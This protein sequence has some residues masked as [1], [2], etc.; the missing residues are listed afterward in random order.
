M[1]EGL[2]FHPLADIFPLMEGAELDALVADIK[3]NG[4]RE[5]IECYEGQVIDGR[6]RYRALQRLGIAPTGYP[7]HFRLLDFRDDGE[8]RAHVISKNIHRR[9]LTPEQKRELIA[10]LLKAEPEKSDRQIAKTVKA[11][12]TFVGKVRAEKEATGDVSTVD[13]RTDTKGRKQPAKK[14]GRRRKA[15]EY[16]E[17]KIRRENEAA[18]AAL[19]AEIAALEAEAEQIA[20]ELLKQIDRNLAQRLHAHLGEG[21][22]LKAVL[23]R[24]LGLEGN[25]T[26]AT[27]VEN[28]PP[29]D[30]GAENKKAQI[31][32]LAKAADAAALDDGLDIPESL[33]RAS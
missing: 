5:K 23:G 25:D 10:K 28:A 16:R 7:K 29:A 22:W 14:A 31:A 2:K 6:N 33:R 3:A 11:S 17:A 26:D 1:S 4:L 12:P 27:P 19:R 8:A 13:T 30:V 18:T 24:G 20:V 32:A 15:R 21:M 9:H